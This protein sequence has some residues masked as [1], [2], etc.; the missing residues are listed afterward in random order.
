MVYSSL[1]KHER[2]KENGGNNIVKKE[3]LEKLKKIK[4]VIL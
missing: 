1:R 4:K 3:R 2:T